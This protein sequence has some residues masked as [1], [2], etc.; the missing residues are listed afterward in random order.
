MQGTSYL[1][2]VDEHLPA[3]YAKAEVVYAQNPALWIEK[4]QCDGIGMKLV[5]LYKGQHKCANGTD[6]MAHKYFDDLPQP[7]D[8]TLRPPS[9]IPD[10]PG[11]S[12]S[13]S[14][15][16]SVSILP[17]SPPGDSESPSLGDSGL[18]HPG[19]N[20][21]PPLSDSKSPQPGGSESPPPRNREAPPICNRHHA[22]HA[23]MNHLRLGTPKTLIDSV[24]R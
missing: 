15:G 6:D 3:I 1:L 4:T 9:E 8:T 2:W 24:T 10:L 23:T 21:S 20:E 19:D 16:D 14:A 7:C 12:L 18:P 22:R 11:N 13:S 17:L 5:K